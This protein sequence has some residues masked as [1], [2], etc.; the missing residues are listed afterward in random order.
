MGKRR[1]TT[2]RWEQN[3]RA[4]HRDKSRGETQRVRPRG[5]KSCRN[6][7]DN[8]GAIVKL[9]FCSHEGTELLSEVPGFDSGSDLGCYTRGIKDIYILYIGSCLPQYP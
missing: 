2:E 1:G 8:F 6:K 9:H 7:C 5:C 4:G 3:V